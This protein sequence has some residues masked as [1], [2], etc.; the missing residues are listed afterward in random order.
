[1]AINRPSSE[2]TY[3]LPFATATPRLT[4]SQQ[5]FQPDSRGEC[6]SNVQIRR[7]VRALRAWTTAQGALTYM[8]PFTTTGVAS[9]PRVDSRS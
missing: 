9:T 3:T 1:M 8:T 7:P 4:T 5:A 2:P 6:V